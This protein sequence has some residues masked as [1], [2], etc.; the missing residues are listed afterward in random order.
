MTYYKSI[1]KYVRVS[2]ELFKEFDRLYKRKEECEL[3][4]FN[5]S[6]DKVSIKSKILKFLNIDGSE[7]MDVKE[8]KRIRLDKIVSYNGEDTKSLN[9]Y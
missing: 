2:N 8:G 7:F 1:D 9:H 5:N 4:Y 3:V 6:N